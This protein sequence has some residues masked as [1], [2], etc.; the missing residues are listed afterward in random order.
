MSTFVPKPNKGN[1]NPNTR[2]TDPRQPDMKGSIWMTRQ[3]I[4][5]CLDATPAHEDLVE[6]ALGG[7]ANGPN[8]VG[9]SASKP[10]VKPVDRKTQAA[11]P[12]PA[13]EPA[14]PD[15]S[16]DDESIPF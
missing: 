12:E 4:Q 15:N 14:A 16:K 13:P 6:I 2:K 8:K 10:W 5:E 1:L 9:L 11:E 7:W 3:L